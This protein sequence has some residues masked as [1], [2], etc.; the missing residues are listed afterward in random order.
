MKF[1]GG[2]AII[3]PL[4]STILIG[5]VNYDLTGFKIYKSKFYYT[6]FF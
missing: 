3:P 4:K 1:R 5:F 2:G 6:A